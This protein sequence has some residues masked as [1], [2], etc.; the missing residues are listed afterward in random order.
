MLYTKYVPLAP[1]ALTYAQIEEIAQK[2]RSQWA[3]V[4]EY[5]SASAIAHYYGGKIDYQSYDSKR[6][7]VHVHFK[8]VINGKHAFDVCTSSF[9]TLKR[10]LLNSVQAVGYLLLHYLPIAGDDPEIGMQVRYI[11]EMTTEDEKRA[12]AQSLRFAC[13]FLMPKNEFIDSWNSDGLAG[14]LKKF[15]VPEQYVKSRAKSLGLSADLLEGV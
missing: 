15:P 6:N 8:G 11:T 13:A 14:C 2:T 1:S 5:L 4:N 10:D 9:Y 3:D 7:T 12:S